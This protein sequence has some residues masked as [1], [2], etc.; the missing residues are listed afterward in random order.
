[1]PGL[2]YHIT[3]G[4][5]VFQ[6]LIFLTAEYILGI[7][8]LYLLIKRWFSFDHISHQS[9]S[10]VSSLRNARLVVWNV[11]LR[12]PWPQGSCPLF[13]SLVTSGMKVRG[14]R[15]ILCTSIVCICTR[16]G[17][18]SYHYQPSSLT[19]V[20]RAIECELLLLVYLC[21]VPM[22]NKGSLGNG[23]WPLI[24]PLSW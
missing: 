20:D 23:S 5:W 15:G 11:P 7:W 22:E 24:W 17:K 1:M 18:K 13:W 3:M 4:K 8:R 14:H 16:D 12:F 10:N 19:R 6:L 21:W 9:L 2:K